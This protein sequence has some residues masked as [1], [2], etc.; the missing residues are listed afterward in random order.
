[1]AIVQQIEAVSHHSFSVFAQHSRDISVIVCWVFRDSQDASTW[2]APSCGQ[3]NGRAGFYSP[4][5]ARAQLLPHVRL[6]IA[7]SMIQNG[8]KHLAR[9]IPSS[10][11]SFLYAS[12]VAS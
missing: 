5:R 2:R 11:T 12:H 4:A 8:N 9:A 10:A 7:S 1:M 6:R 3:L